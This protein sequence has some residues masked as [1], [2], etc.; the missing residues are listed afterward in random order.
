MWTAVSLWMV[1]GTGI[2]AFALGAANAM[3]AGQSPWPWIAA[4][5]LL[6]LG[7]ILLFTLLYFAIAW[8]R[9]SA[10]PA[11]ARLDPHRALRMFRREFLTIAGWAPRMMTYRRVSRDPVPAPASDPVMLLH[12]VLCN[13]GV[14]R[15]M[16]RRLARAGIG[17]LYAPSYGPPLASIDLFADQIAAKIDQILAATGAKQVSIVSHS[18]GGL[19]ARAYVAKYGGDKVR[20]VITIAAP[21][22]GSVHAW[23]FP[24]TSLAQL[25]PGNAWLDALPAPAPGG[26][27]EFVSIWSWHDSMVAPQTSARLEHGRNVE[28]VGVG[29]N[30]LLTDPEV[31]KRVI[32]ELRR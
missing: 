20:R 22:A 21:H 27:P 24:G 30:A 26:S 23:L 1:I 13:A 3:R 29:H 4:I 7:L 18:M 31:A 9:R 19:V 10:R 28:L 12:G 14:W 11:Y 32:E 5:P 2:V 6:Y 8:V 25:R 16:K 15:S 17:P